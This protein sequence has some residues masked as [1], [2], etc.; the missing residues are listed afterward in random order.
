MKLEIPASIEQL[1][2]YIA[3]PESKALIERLGA[4]LLEWKQNNPDAV[5]FFLRSDALV[6]GS[7][8]DREAQEMLA[9]NESAIAALTYADNATGR[10]ATVLLAELALNDIGW[11]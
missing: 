9:G 5:L 10:E 7:L 1:N 2:R 3:S 8:G 6:I 11:L 4:A